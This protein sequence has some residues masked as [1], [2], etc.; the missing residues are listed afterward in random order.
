MQ[1]TVNWGKVVQQ[2]VPLHQRR[3]RIIVW[4]LVLINGVR[5]LHTTF[6]DYRKASLYG[7]RITGQTIYLEKAI[8]DRFDYINR[9]IWIETAA[10]VNSFYLH[11]KVE[12]APAVYMYNRY[13]PAHSYL[14]GE[15]AI[16][17][18]KRW[19]ALLAAPLSAPGVDPAEWSDA[20]PRLFLRNKNEGQLAQDFIIWVPETLVYN[21]A[22]LRALVA[23]YKLAG[24]RYAIMTY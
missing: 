12:A 11:N 5:S 1:V 2:Q 6:L 20:G 10:N 21:D 16:H 18:N 7:L 19:K 23:L 15:Y 9:G 13:D 22:E 14:V 3:K 24:K 17:A 4:L 8:N